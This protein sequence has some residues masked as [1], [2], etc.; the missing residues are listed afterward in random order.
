MSAP[1]I[2]FGKTFLL[3]TVFIA[4]TFGV[5]GMYRMFGGLERTPTQPSDRRELPDLEWNDL[6]G[7]AWKLADQK[8]RVVVVNYFATWCAPCRREIPDLNDVAKEYTPRGVSFAAISLDTEQEMGQPV[9]PVLREF[10]VDNRLKIPV[11]L[12]RQPSSLTTVR[13]IPTTVLID[14]HGRVAQVIVGQFDAAA[15]KRNLNVLLTEP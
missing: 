5:Y 12:G 9:A 7:S 14:K 13:S 8:G 1:R 10:A 11:L 2:G 3:G 4:A 15:L 6:S